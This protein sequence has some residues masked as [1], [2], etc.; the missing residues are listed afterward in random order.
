MQPSPPMSAVSASP[1]TPTSSVTSSVSATD[2][3]SLGQNL[4]QYQQYLG[5]MPA[6][7]D[8]P[9]LQISK[10]D[11]L[12]SGELHTEDLRE[13]EQLYIEHCEVRQTFL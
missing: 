6:N 11:I 5:K 1:K 12:L 7:I 8:I 10:N 2:L 4:G 13:F 9:S 3:K